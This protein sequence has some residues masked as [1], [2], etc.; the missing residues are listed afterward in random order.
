MIVDGVAKVKEGQPSLLN[1]INL[2]QL[3][4]KVKVAQSA[5]DAKKAS[6][7]EAKTE[8]NLLQVYKG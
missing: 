7:P 4:H 5:A 1:L 8:Q 6:Q 3:R 2:K